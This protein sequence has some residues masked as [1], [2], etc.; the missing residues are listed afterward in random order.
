[1]V[2]ALYWNSDVFVLW[3]LK[4]NPHHF[5]VTYNSIFIDSVLPLENSSLSAIKTWMFDFEKLS[6]YCKFI[7]YKGEKGKRDKHT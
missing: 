3:Q 4:E 6:S 5:N 2:S 7:N 1:M